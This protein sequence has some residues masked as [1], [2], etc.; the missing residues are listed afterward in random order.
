MPYEEIA[1]LAGVTSLIWFGAI[2]VAVIAYACW[3][4]NQSR[5]D[6]AARMPLRED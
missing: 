2:F 3:P 4:R 5:F 1:R 6:A